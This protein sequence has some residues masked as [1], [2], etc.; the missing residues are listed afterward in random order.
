[1][2]VVGHRAAASLAQ[3]LGYTLAKVRPDVVTLTRGGSREYDAFRT[4]PAGSWLVALAFPRYPSETLELLDY[5]R[6]EGLSVGAI[7][8]NLLSPAA[9]RADV[10]LAVPADPVSFIDSYCAPQALVAALLVEY[11]LRARERTEALLARFERTASR[12]SIFHAGH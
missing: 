5:A 4:V 3:F 2:C 6:E 1:V 10:T 8:D 11:G 9:K 12:R 7:T